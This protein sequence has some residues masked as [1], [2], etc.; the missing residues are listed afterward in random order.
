MV[1]SRT[2]SFKLC[3]KYSYVADVSTIYRVDSEWV[4]DTGADAYATGYRA[5]IP[6]DTLDTRWVL[7]SVDFNEC[8]NCVSN[9]YATYRKQTRNLSVETKISNVVASCDEV[10]EKN[11]DV[12]I[13]VPVGR[14]EK[15]LKTPEQKI[16]GDVQ[17]YRVRTRTLLTPASTSYKWSFYNDTNLLNSGYNYTGKTRTK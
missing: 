3:N 14:Y 5:D 12:Y 16:Y 17:F 4:Y 6:Y 15:V 9:P 1:K 7:Q 10:E 13:N 8:S 2:L 11:V